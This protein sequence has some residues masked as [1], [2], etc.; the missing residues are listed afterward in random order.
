M[1]DCPSK[2]PGIKNYGHIPHL[3]GSR[4][5]P[6]DHHCDAGQARI[7]IA[8]LRDHHDLVIVLEKLDGSNVGVARLDGTIYPL[9]RSGYLATS[10]PYA[11]HQLFAA[12]AYENRDRFLAAL[13]DGERMCGEWLTQ[14]HGTRYE[15]R[16]EPFVAFDLMEGNTRHRFDEL[17]ER[18]RA[19]EFITPAVLHRGGPL[20][21]D[22]AMRHLAGGGFH[23]AL[24]PVEGAVWRVERNALV[25]PGRGGERRCV[26]DFMAK[27]VRP[28][29]IDGCY[30]PEINGGQAYWNWNH[31]KR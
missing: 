1:A 17:A 3:P 31:R 27:Y 29:K 20:S 12:W 5:G 24:D 6:G 2:P 19:G 30:L 15:L 25:T 23:G 10:S 22:R 13:R 28:D 18:A 16:H 26:V 11:Q 4:M 9:N 14:A 8:A 7:A 21:I